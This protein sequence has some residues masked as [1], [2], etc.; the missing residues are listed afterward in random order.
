QLVFFG[1]EV[2]FCRRP[3][4]DD[5]ALFLQF[6]YLIYRFFLHV[7]YPALNLHVFLLKVN[8]FLTFFF[9]FVFFHYHFFLFCFLFLFPLL[10]FLMF[11]P[12]PP[13]LS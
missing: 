7:F 4:V 8:H 10:S 13:Q 5:Y 2:V 6:A 3:L 1:N 9:S 11:S 12:S